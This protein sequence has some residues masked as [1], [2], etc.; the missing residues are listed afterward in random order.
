M[1][2][3]TGRSRGFGFV[4]FSS[5]EEATKAVTEMNGRIIVSRPLY[6][7]LAQRKEERQQHLATLRMQRTM[8]RQGNMPM[9]TV[10]GVGH[11][12]LQ[13]TYICRFRVKCHSTNNLSCWAVPC[14]HK[15]RE[16]S[17]L[18]AIDHGRATTSSG[19]KAPMVEALGHNNA[20]GATC[21]EEDP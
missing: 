10:S 12:L 9:S 2:D 6:V 11:L 8:A 16:R 1:V 18:L 14:H 19:T 3:E 7:A 15:D 20:T 13:H 4:C 5:P 21:P 17:S